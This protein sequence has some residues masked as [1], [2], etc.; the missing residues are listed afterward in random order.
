MGASA[1]LAAGAGWMLWMHKQR[2]SAGQDARR[3][4][5]AGTSL[6]FLS[7]VLLLYAAATA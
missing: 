2:E 4:L 5:T 3:L 7:M 1:V 6:L